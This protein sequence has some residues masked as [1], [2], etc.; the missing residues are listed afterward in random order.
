[1]DIGDPSI[2]PTPPDANEAMRWTH[3][4][5][6]RR[7]LDGAWEGDLEE[8]I[9]REVGRERQSAWGV[10]KTTSMP[11]A[12]I[13]R[14]SAAL[15]LTQ[16]EVYSQDAPIFGI[17]ADAIDRAGLWPRMP[18][19]QALTIGLRECAWRVSVGTDGL[20]YRPVYPDLMMAAASPDAP[21]VP[22]ALRELRWRDGFGWCWDCLSIAAPNDPEYRVER[23]AD[24]VD[25]S[26]DV[27]GGDFS[28]DAYPYRRA[29]GTPILPYVLH[30]AESLGDRLW[31]WR[32]NWETV[33]ASLDLG[34][35]F[36][37][38]GHV[39]RDASFPQRYTLDCAFVGG[40]TAD[41]V[42]GYSRTE[43]VADPA[44]IMRAES[45]PEARQPLISQFQAGADPAM[46]ESVIA[47]MANRIAIDAGLPASDLQRSS[48]GSA[49]SGYA[50]SLS[51]AG[52][53]E[54]AR[55]YAPIFRR[56]DERLIAVT[57]TL[58]NRALGLSL[59]ETGYR[60]VYRD[61]PLSP[62]ELQA[63]RANV[64]EL[65]GA[66]MI[67]RVDAYRELNPG[68]T[69]AAAR[70]ALAQIDAERMSRITI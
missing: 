53:R 43:I 6:T 33:Q 38:L 67:S 7:M 66:G 17:L 9:G 44:V 51:N 27:L 16:P 55:R 41:D 68:L 36:T 25:L 8:R 37:F 23:F 65:L 31:N 50:I 45:M 39:L 24:G 54:A 49:Q 5:R 34:V 30:H 21:D 64:L 12:A 58:L 13:C 18:R 32:G 19:Y 47:N 3:T 46:L 11:L 57:A 14:E 29:D 56:S 35:N 48:S 61:L 52:K 4:R 40:G 22:V 26:A 15:Y 62:D 42:T 63:R 10:A 69:E 2:I 59:P 1:M 70:L 60:V 20:Q 28:G